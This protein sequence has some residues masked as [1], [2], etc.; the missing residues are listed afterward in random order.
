[1]EVVEI[2]KN[3]TS[4]KDKIIVCGNNDIIYNLSNRFAAS[5]YSFQ[6]SPEIDELKNKEFYDDLNKNLPKIIVLP[7]DYF[8]YNKMLEFISNHEYKELWYSN[9][10][11][12]K[13]YKI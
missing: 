8:D 5:R 6:I 1:M 4:K 12:V 2:I 10:K 3:S 11:T 9:E 7:N 13:V